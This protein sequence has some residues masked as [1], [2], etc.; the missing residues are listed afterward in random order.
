MN[1]L[2]V[3]DDASEVV[4]NPKMKKMKLSTLLAWMNANLDIEADMVV[5]TKTAEQSI[6]NGT[7]TQITWN[8]NTLADPPTMHSTSAN[9]EQLYAQRTGWY[10][11]TLNASFALS[12]GGNFR[13][14]AI[15]DSSGNLLSIKDADNSGNTS[16]YFPITCDVYLT[17]GDYIYADCFQNS[18]GALAIQQLSNRYPSFSLRFLREG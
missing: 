9:T 13:W 3:L 15:R 6:P 2:F 1:D 4:D 14:I 17:A 16:R 11:A 5:V 8:V 18:G 7:V 12:V 10:R